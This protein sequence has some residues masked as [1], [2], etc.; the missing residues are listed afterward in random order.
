MLWRLIEEKRL[1]N[2]MTKVQLAEH[3]NIS[4]SYIT[5]LKQ[6]SIIPSYDVANRIAGWLDMTP[7]QVFDA[8]SPAGR[9]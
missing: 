1:E 2:N 5:R 6:N 7:G 4:P 8:L 3:L 9:N